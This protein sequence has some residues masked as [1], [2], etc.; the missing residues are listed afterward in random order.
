MSQK[1]IQN[2]VAKFVS[3]I[4]KNGI[5]AKKEKE[6]RDIIIEIS[7]EDKIEFAE[8]IRSFNS[9]EKINN[10]GEGVW[11]IEHQITDKELHDGFLQNRNHWRFN[12][13]QK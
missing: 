13:K 8:W 3:F 10:N 5:N 1:T 7:N 4:T 2:P 9:L 11:I 12:K 6:L